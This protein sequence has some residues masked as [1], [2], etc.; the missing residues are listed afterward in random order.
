MNDN[1]KL[2]SPLPG[3]RTLNLEVEFDFLQ[4]FENENVGSTIRAGGTAPQ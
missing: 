1:V 3:P 4:F 2:T